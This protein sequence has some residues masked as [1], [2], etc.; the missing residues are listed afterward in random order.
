M[1]TI[2]SVR[3]IEVDASLRPYLPT[4]ATRLGYLYPDVQFV[5]R[6]DGVELVGTD[7]DLAAM[8]REVL[9]AVYRE[10]VFAETL[11]LRRTLIDGLLA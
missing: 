8:R 5:V 2:A 3:L 10:R 9:H 6:T 11:P 7:I 4:A 1:D